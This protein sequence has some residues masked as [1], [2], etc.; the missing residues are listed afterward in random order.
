ME[1]SVWKL[2]RAAF[3]VVMITSAT[4]LIAEGNVIGYVVYAAEIVRFILEILYVVH[5]FIW[6]QK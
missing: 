4:I 1:S 6:H 5:P 3:L 2:I